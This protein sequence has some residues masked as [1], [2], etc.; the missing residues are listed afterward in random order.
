MNDNRIMVGNGNT[1]GSVVVSGNAEQHPNF[2]NTKHFV[3]WADWEE[4]V[5]ILC[6]ALKKLIGYLFM[7][8]QEAE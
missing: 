3:S 4:R 6:D 7:G 5:T 2:Q 1:V 8:F